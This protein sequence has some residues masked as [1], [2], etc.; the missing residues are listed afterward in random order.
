MSKQDDDSG[1]SAG[2]FKGIEESIHNL[3]RYGFAGGIF[4]ATFGVG[5]QD[6]RLTFHFKPTVITSSDAILAFVTLGI[7]TLVYAVSRHTA[8]P[9]N[10]FCGAQL[11]RLK[12]FRSFTGSEFDTR[13]E[14]FQKNFQLQS[15]FDEDVAFFLCREH[16]GKSSEQLWP[17]ETQQQLFRQ[18]S[19][20]HL[21]NSAWMILFVAAIFHFFAGRVAIAV[22]IFSAF[23]VLFFTALLADIHVFKREA[24]LLKSKEGC[25][26]KLLGKAGI[27]SAE[28]DERQ[29]CSPWFTFR[30]ILVSVFLFVVMI[31]GHQYMMP[32]PFPIP[33]GLVHCALGVQF[34]FFAFTFSCIISACTCGCDAR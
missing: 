20:I 2:I 25:V 21:L 5:T 24:A 3:L 17:S 4:L 22:I 34:A 15:V 14:F 18:H 28:G 6:G 19:E 31:S 23:E 8:V 32:A 16:R 29:N 26:D 7:G 10:I 33:D 9:L 27:K 11:R 1:K 13:N 12:W 30:L